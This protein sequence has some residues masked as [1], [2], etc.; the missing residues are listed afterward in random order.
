M[1]AEWEERVPQEAQSGYKT[2]HDV[3]DE[4][5]GT[6]KKKTGTCKIK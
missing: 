4:E 2:R 6:L 3:E 1:I 5:G